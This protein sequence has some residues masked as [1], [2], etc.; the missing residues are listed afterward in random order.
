MAGAA[1]SAALLERTRRRGGM[2]PESSRRQACCRRQPPVLVPAA[3]ACTA[4]ASAG[5]STG[6]RDSHH[7]HHRYRHAIGSV[8]ALARRTRLHVEPLIATGRDHRRRYNRGDV[9]VPLGFASIRHRHRRRAARAFRAASPVYRDRT[10]KS[11]TRCLRSCL[12]AAPRD[13]RHLR[14]VGGD[15]ERFCRS[16]RCT[17]NSTAQFVSFVRRRSASAQELAPLG[18]PVTVAVNDV[19]AGGPK[20]RSSRSCVPVAPIS[21]F[22]R[23][24]PADFARGIP[25]SEPMPLVA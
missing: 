10:A 17:V 14:N 16:R 11:T 25:H 15:V 19:P 8:A 6:L 5:A 22:M 4:G 3:A 13:D 2:Q 18:V 7:H 20:L 24:G 21:L 23:I 9:V 1:R 12:P